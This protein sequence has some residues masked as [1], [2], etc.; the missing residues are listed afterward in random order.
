M[1]DPNIIVVV[2]DNGIQQNHP[3]INQLPGKDFWNPGNNG[4]PLNSGDNHGTTVAGVI[5]GILN[6][7]V[8]IVGI[9]PN[10][11][12][13]SARIGGTSTT[14]NTNDWTANAPAAEALAWAQSIGAR[15]TVRSGDFI[16]YAS[17][18]QKYNDTW[19]N[20]HGLLHFA[21]TGNANKYGLP[22]P[23]NLGSVVAVGA[24]NSSGNRWDNG[25]QGS[26]WGDKI[27][28]NPNNPGVTFLAPGVDI[29]TT[30]RTG[31]DGYVN[32]DYYNTNGTSYAAP[33]AAGV[34]ALAFSYHPSFTAN[35]VK[36]TMLETSEQ[37]AQYELPGDAY[38]TS[39]YATVKEGFGRI[40]ARRML[41]DLQQGGTPGGIVSMNMHH[42]FYAGSNHD[43]YLIYKSWH[44]DTGTV[45]PGQDLGLALVLG[46]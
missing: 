8:G 34:A 23:A 4:G 22:F 27:P 7:N 14:T 28:A 25:S 32:G 39:S 36:Y 2:L 13:V 3:D 44:A 41:K 18:E 45:S 21:A 46:I 33:Y 24:F 6:N 5:S 19:N 38:A 16:Y 11:K 37:V 26:T 42:D 10:V 31:S 20:G 1:G 29:W 35:D 15:I 40:S 17:I 43:D 12:V 30:D 9:A